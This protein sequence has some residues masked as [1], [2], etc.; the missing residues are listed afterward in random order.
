MKIDLTEIVVVLDRSGSMSSCRKDAEGGLNTFIDKQKKEPGQANFSH[1]WM[2]SQIEFV[3]RGVPIA[4]VPQCSLVP[5]GGTAL[6]DAVGRA[7]IETGERLSKIAE[8]DRPGLVVFV[9]ITDGGENSSEEFR[10]PQIKEM[11]KHQTEVYKWQFTFLGANQDAFATG[12]GMGIPTAACA[13]YDEQKTSGVILTAS[14]NVSRMRSATA[15]GIGICNSYTD[16][17]R[18]AVSSK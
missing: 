1:W 4:D 6:L 16:E 9:I 2:R 15:R 5:R 10:L 18:A 11:I 12:S 13:N 17:E 7:I 3:H 8:D 14:S